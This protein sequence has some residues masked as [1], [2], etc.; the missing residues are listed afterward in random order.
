MEWQNVWSNQ[1]EKWE[2]KTSQRN[3]SSMGRENTYMHVATENVHLARNANSRCSQFWYFLKK[4]MQVSFA[5][6]IHMKGV[7]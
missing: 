2:L 1:N 4:I 5:I 6:N 7:P 3:I